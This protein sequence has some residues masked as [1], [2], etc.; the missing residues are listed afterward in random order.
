MSNEEYARKLKGK[1]GVKRII[2]AAG[3]SKDGLRAAYRHES[4]F[5]QLIWLNGILLVLVFV[6]DFGPA[7]RMML[8]IASFLSLIVEL[9]NT[10]IEAAVDH[11]STA[12]H[13]LAK[14]A[15]DAGS[16]AQMLALV[17][18]VVLWFMAVWREYGLNLF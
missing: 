13:E 18:L 2:N 6:L 10:A 8:I 15:K 12:R 5:R 7:T 3:Y 4:A 17:L 9:F 16:A 11:T 1:R 14:R